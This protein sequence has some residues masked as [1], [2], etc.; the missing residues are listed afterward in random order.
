M[1]NPR[2]VSSVEQSRVLPLQIAGFIPKHLFSGDVQ[3]PVFGDKVL[4]I[5]NKRVYQLLEDMKT[6]QLMKQMRKLVDS[7]DYPMLI[8]EGSWM[9]NGAPDYI[10]N[11]FPYSWTQ[12]WNELQTIQDMGVRLQITTG[13]KHTIARIIEI[14]E[15]YS[16]PEHPSALR[17]VA[18]DKHIAALDLIEG[19]GT[20]MAIKLLA[21]FGSLSSIARAPTASLQDVGDVGPKLARKIYEFFHEEYR[22]PITREAQA[23]LDKI[24][25]FGKPDSS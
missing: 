13:E 8:L 9:H 12:A 19:V 16:K 3:S 4:L 25:L 2:F 11:A 7:C 15:Y 14:C 1:L 24:A 22:A 5:E 21:Y 20:K 6:G 10:L 23:E 18:G 17:E